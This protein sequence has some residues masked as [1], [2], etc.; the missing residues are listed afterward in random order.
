MLLIQIHSLCVGCCIRAAHR[1]TSCPLYGRGTET[2]LKAAQQPREVASLCCIALPYIRI[3]VRALVQRDWI[4]LVMVR[5]AAMEIREQ[6]RRKYHAPHLD[7]STHSKPNT[8]F[9]FSLSYTPHHP[10]PVLHP[11]GRTA[12]MSAPPSA[13]RNAWNDSG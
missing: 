9:F 5:G 8:D 2:K 11:I 12:T 10:C 1:A 6:T 7:K 13:I 3:V 4:G